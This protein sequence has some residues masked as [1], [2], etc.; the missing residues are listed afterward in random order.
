[1]SLSHLIH[2][3]LV[4]LLSSSS[5]H[6]FLSSHQLVHT[7]SSASSSNSRWRHHVFTHKITNSKWDVDVADEFIERIESV[8]V[9]VAGVAGITEAPTLI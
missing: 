5:I 3:L 4:V 6:G 9:A 7:S 2:F 1:M 8:K